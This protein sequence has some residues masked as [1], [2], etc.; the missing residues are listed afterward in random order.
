MPRK[1]KA[2]PEP[3]P[4]PSD[5]VDEQQA[6]IDA[7]F[8][9]AEAPQPEKPA[10]TGAAFITRHG[11]PR[12][13]VARLIASRL[14]LRLQEVVGG[15]WDGIKVVTAKDLAEA[16]A[17]ELPPASLFSADVSTPAV[18][19]LDAVCPDCRQAV[20]MSTKLTVQLVQDDTGAELKIKSKSKARTHVHGQT[21]LAAAAGEGLWDGRIPSDPANLS[22]DEATATLGEIVGKTIIPTYDEIVAEG[23]EPLDLGKCPFPGCDLA[24]EHTGAHSPTTTADDDELGDP[25]ASEG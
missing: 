14:E 21:T 8:D 11:S 13:D 16:L 10:V 15:E 19:T 3:E 23:N 12:Q 6:K 25:E 24:A 17:E 2:A 18:I 22:T 20:T 9:A 7:A 5:D 1:R 4:Q